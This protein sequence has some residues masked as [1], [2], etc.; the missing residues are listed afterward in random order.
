MSESEF[1]APLVTGGVRLRG[2]VIA[3]PVY[4]V[5]NADPACE[6]LLPIPSLEKLR[7]GV[8]HN[9]CV[10]CDGKW[11][12]VDLTGVAGAPLFWLDH[13]PSCTA[14]AAVETEIRGLGGDPRGITW[15]AVPFEGPR[16][17]SS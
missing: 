15:E 8:L 4:N 9:E 14:V 10:G 16:R 13:M 5:H 17:R 7:D 2:A 11:R 6:H 3:L 1:L 12:G